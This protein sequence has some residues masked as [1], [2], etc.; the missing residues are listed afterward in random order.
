[1]FALKAILSLST[2]KAHASVNKFT[3]S[4]AHGAKTTE[5]ANKRQENSWQRLG[6]TLKT[7][8][9]IGASLFAG[10]VAASP[11]LQASLMMISFEIRELMMALGDE[12]A[13]MIND[14]ILPVVR[15]MVDL[16]LAMPQPIRQTIAVAIGL[17]VALGALSVVI[18]ILMS[19]SW[20]IVAVILAVAAV[21]VGVI[22]LFKNWGDVMDWFN[23]KI[24]AFAGWIVVTS[25]NVGNFIKSFK[26]KPDEGLINFFEK[27]YDVVKWVWT[28]IEGFGMFLGNM[29]HTIGEWFFNLGSDAYNWGKHL[30]ENF[31]DGIKHA[32]DNTKDFFKDIGDDIADFLGFSRPPPKGALKDIDKWGIH[33]MQ[34]LSKSWESGMNLYL[35][36]TIKSA[37]PDSFTPSSM[38]NSISSFSS[39]SSSVSLTVN[40][41][42][43]VIRDES[44][45]DALAEKIRLLILSDLQAN[46]R[47]LIS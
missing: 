7:I 13:P 20:P 37:M 5:L 8:S 2:K 43:P 40:V 41:D 1:M 11:Q 44:D 32:W 18:G 22:W 30:I 26:I 21:I 23:E 45:I 47:G 36:P 27:L 29:F 16:F 14:Y 38:G 6:S 3:K 34:I 12:L 19:V 10:M 28:K 33:A 9:L 15:K 17:T 31:V 46:T 24:M 35:T 25:R 42:N 4:V 39:S